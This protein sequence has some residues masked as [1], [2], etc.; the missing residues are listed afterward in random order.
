MFHTLILNIGDTWAMSRYAEGK[1]HAFAC[2]LKYLREPL[3]VK[4]LF[5][6]FKQ[7]CFVSPVADADTVLRW[8]SDCLVKL[9]VS[10]FFILQGLDIHLYLDIR[11]FAK[12]LGMKCQPITSTFHPRY[13]LEHE[14]GFVEMVEGR[15]ACVY[16][17]TTIPSEIDPQPGQTIEDAKA[18]FLVYKDTEQGIDVYPW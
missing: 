2:A 5:I 6:N 13:L 16:V 15:Y 8:F 18:A 11:Q 17:P 9:K 4:T 7:A 1:M 10:K 3:N 12:K 14:S